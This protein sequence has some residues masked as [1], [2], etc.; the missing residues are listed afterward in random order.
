MRKDAFYK[1]KELIRAVL[2]NLFDLAGRTRNNHEAAGRTS[3][4][5]VKDCKGKDWNLYKEILIFYLTFDF[6]EHQY[7]VSV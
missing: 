7:T 1:W 3:K 2:P 4:L 6:V 5:K